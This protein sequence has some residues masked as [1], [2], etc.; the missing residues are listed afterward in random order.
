MS[1]AIHGRDD[2]G[3]PGVRMLLGGVFLRLT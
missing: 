2:D 1:C 3:N